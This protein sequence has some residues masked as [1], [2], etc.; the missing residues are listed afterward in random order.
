MITF[1]LLFDRTV[2]VCLPW[3]PEGRKHPVMRT[4]TAGPHTLYPHWLFSKSPW[5]CWSWRLILEHV[6]LRIIANIYKYPQPSANTL[7]KNIEKIPMFHIYIFYIVY[8][9]YRYDDVLR[10]QGSSIFLTF[11]GRRTKCTGIRCLSVICCTER[12]C[13]C[14]HCLHFMIRQPGGRIKKNNYNGYFQSWHKSW[15]ILDPA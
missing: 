14:R 10:I 4:L 13:S 6:I 9:L 12:S 8:H 1:F 15:S 7:F 2:R 3:A 5:V 11:W